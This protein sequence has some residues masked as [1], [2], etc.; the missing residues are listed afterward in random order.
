MKYL[1]III[2]LATVDVYAQNTGS[3]NIGFLDRRGFFRFSNYKTLLQFLDYRY[4]EGIDGLVYFPLIEGD[5][6]AILST[7]VT[8]KQL[9]ILSYFCLSKSGNVRLWTPVIQSHLV[10][11]SISR[12][13]DKLTE[14]QFYNAY[15]NRKGVLVNLGNVEVEKAV[16]YR[17]LMDNFL[18]YETDISSDLVL[19]QV[20]VHFNKNRFSYYCK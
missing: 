10:N 7:D 19:S 8:P 20:K 18:V 4:K 17:L 2:L 5:K 15:V 12:R 3:D 1:L 9:N 11:D 14:E 16:I 6:K 13:I